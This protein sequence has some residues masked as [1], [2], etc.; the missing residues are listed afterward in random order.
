MTLTTPWMANL[1]AFI[2]AY[3]AFWFAVPFFLRRRSS[4][5]VPLFGAMLKGFGQ[6]FHISHRS[7]RLSSR[8]GSPRHSIGGS[9][10]PEIELRPEC[11]WNQN[12][13]TTSNHPYADAVALSLDAS[14]QYFAN[15]V[16][17]H[18]PLDTTPTIKVHKVGH[19]S[20]ALLRLL[21]L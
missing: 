4:G 2:S 5:F 10:A 6:F 1:T 18:H 11:T 21:P 13:L 19:S 3:R 12:A 20:P 14:L 17:L 7:L 16:L 9:H 15:L 8:T